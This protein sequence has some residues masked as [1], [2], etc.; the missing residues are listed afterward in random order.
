MGSHSSKMA[1]AK[2]FTGTIPA[3]IT[4]FKAEGG[5]NVDVVPAL[6]NLHLEA[7][8][9]GFY[10]CGNTGE[11]YAC[12]VAERK[13]MLEATLAAVD[14]KV[15]IL[16]HVG[17]CPL[18]DAVELAKHAASVGAAGVSSVVPTDK[19]NDLGAAAEYFTGIGAA[20][21]LPFYV[22]WVAAHADSS[23]DAAQYLEA[24]KSVPNFQG[25]KFTDTNFFVFQQLAYLAPSVLGHP[26]NAVTGPDEMAL[27][28]LA[29][30][31]DGAIGSTYNVQPK[32]N[33][34]MHAAFKSGDMATAMQLQE[35][36][37]CVIAKL[38]VSCDCKSR[39][40]NII[41]GLKAIYRSRG[42]DVG[43]CH[44]DDAAAKELSPE[45]EKDLVDY[46]NSLDW[47]VE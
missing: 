1:A 25:I 11:G 41:A 43:H 39:G 33:C 28:G 17:A 5:I 7:G 15:P 20:S 16:V 26:L 34:Q 24:M 18:A 37:N 42:L 4:P 21:D 14:G 32:L 12:T 23:V 8:V 31:S 38:I 45:A 10:L 13:E 46:C 6:V 29:M 35:K 22:Y 44:K 40:L 27:A 36:L 3:L 30:G 9:G 47:T 2:L 19:P